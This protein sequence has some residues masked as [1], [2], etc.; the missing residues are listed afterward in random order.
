MC[1]ARGSS[2]A[3][4]EPESGHASP[5]DVRVTSVGRDDD[6]AHCFRQCQAVL[7]SGHRRGNCISL[8]L[9]GARGHV[10]QAE[11]CQSLATPGRAG[12]GASLAVPACPRGSREDLDDFGITVSERVE[13]VKSLKDP[14][15]VRARVNTSR[16]G[17]PADAANCPGELEFAVASGLPVGRVRARAVDR[18]DGRPVFVDD[19][20]D[21]HARQVALKRQNLAIVDDRDVEALSLP[22]H[23]DADPCSHASQHGLPRWRPHSG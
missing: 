6:F 5:L 20:N 17:C 10:L 9:V 15:V 7:T 12:P 19:V 2:S 22:A 18:H 21:L 4:P 16:V 8:V 1:P 14:R 11:R 23:I 3:T 13:K